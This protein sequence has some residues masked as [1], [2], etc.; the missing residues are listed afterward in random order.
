ME[1]QEKNRLTV[2]I[3]GQTYTLMGHASAEHMKRVA[4]GVNERM[5]ELS[6]KNLRLD[7]TKL[8]VLVALNY[9]DELL[10]L[11]QEYEELLKLIE[12]ERK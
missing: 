2:K 11:Q 4:H 3:Y 1:E 10:K 12:D 9:A 8:A 5:E 6:A 7:S